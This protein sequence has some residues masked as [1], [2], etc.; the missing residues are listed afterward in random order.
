MTETDQDRPEPADD[1]I[2]LE[3]A[4]EQENEKQPLSLEI[5]VETKSACERHVTVTISAEDIDRYFS[6]QFDEL[7]PKA[8]VPGFRPGR[9]PASSSKAASESRSPI[10]SRARCC[11]TA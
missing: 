2:A 1:E 11:W 3:E 7:M 9:A 8:S 6:E 10:R 5:K 4:L